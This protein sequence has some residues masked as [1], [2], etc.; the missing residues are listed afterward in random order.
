MRNGG[1]RIVTV[2]APGRFRYRRLTVDTPEDFAS[3][4]AAF[5]AE[6]GRNPAFGFRDLFE[7]ADLEGVA[8]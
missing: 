8:V 3:V 6:Y 2:S 1:F 5:E 4:A 7:T